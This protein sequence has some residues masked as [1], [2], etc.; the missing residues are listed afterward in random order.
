MNALL[1]GL[2]VFAVIPTG[3]GK[4][5]IVFLFTMAIR[6]LR[7]ESKGLVIVGMPLSLIISQQLNNPWCPVLTMSMGGQLMGLDNKGEA[8][9]ITLGEAL[10]GT[11]CAVFMHPESTTTETGQKLLRGLAKEDLILGLFV[12]EVHQVCAHYEG[13]HGPWLTHLCPHCNHHLCGT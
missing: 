10:S 8:V 2:D 3:S 13:S 5:L 7:A 12:D 9:T 4:T 11:Y 6:K 1:N